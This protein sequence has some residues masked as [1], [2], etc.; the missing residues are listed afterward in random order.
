MTLE[1]ILDK[2]LI[3]VRGTFEGGWE[4]FEDTLEFALNNSSPSDFLRRNG[5]GIGN[6][7]ARQGIFVVITEVSDET[8]QEVTFL[9]SRSWW[10][11]SHTFKLSPQLV[12]FFL[13]LFHDVR[14]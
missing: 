6:I 12:K 7:L 8:H 11:S 4:L 10:R 13:D 9:P 14:K 3:I 1:G 2:L 5:L